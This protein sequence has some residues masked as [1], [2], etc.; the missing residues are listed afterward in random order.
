LLL[1]P[2]CGVVRSAAEAPARM[3]G[4]VLP[5]GKP[6]RPS[7]DALLSDLMRVADLLVTRVA[8][9]SHE[10]EERV[11]TQEAQLEAARWRLESLQRSTQLAAGPNSLSGLLD[12]VVY[13]TI[14]AWLI[15]DQWL[16][17]HGEAV[18]PL[19][20]AFQRT[21][22]E[23]WALAERHLPAAELAEART[24]I[25]AWRLEHPVIR[26]E[27]LL[28][29]P[30]FLSLASARQTKSATSG[31]LLGLVG[32]D[33]LSG[34]E[35]AARQIEEAR[36][37]GLRAL[38]FLQRA[39][40]LVASEVEFRVR[41]GRSAPEVQQLLAD[42][43][44]ITLTLEELS[45]SATALPDQFSAEREA[46]VAQLADELERQR[47][48]LLEDLSTAREPLEGLLDE[49]RQTLEAGARMSAELTGTLTVLDGF[50][51]R[52]EGPD[53]G[54]EPAPAADAPPA[55][56][57]D[58]RDYGE[59]AERV[60]GAA[61]ELAALVDALDQRLPEARRLLE[62]TARE[63]RGTVDHAARRALEVGLALVAAA[64]LAA[65][66]VR[67]TGRP[68]RPER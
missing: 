67:R 66:L 12:L 58:V 51:G 52:F 24:L 46:T 3:A 60:G 10:F 16:P 64:G 22:E 14:F 53:D 21:L 39:P 68:A 19:L 44:R 17:E 20:V 62:E 47:A 61:R 4:A 9:A 38:Y 29:F 31:S 54:P 50:V 56:P 7:T 49:T 43:E 41:D 59:A 1:L 5:G 37:F 33:P 28:E 57:F 65:W 35:P 11:A 42:T 40:R 48:G 32:L 2:A 63:G 18:R 25:D 27:I 36:Q 15:E 30:S 55:R 8:E 23:G 26:R 34:L 45:A 13:T 6:A